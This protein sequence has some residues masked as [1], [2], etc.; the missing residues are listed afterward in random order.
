MKN[1]KDDEK[2]VLGHKDRRILQVAP[3]QESVTA[4]RPMLNMPNMVMIGSFGRNSGKTTLATTLIKHWRNQ[5]PV[6][7]LKVVCVSENGECHR[8]RA[9]CG[10][11]TGFTGGFVLQEEFG[12]APGKDTSR[13]L[14]AGA[15]RVFLLK[16]KREALPQALRAF[17]Q[18]VP[19]GVLIVCESN[20]LRKIVQPGVF[21]MAAG[22]VQ[23][24]AD[25]TSSK[26][27][28]RAV[29]H[30]ADATLLPQSDKALQHIRV[31]VL[32]QGGLR[33]DWYEAGEPLAVKN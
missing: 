20:S 6:F 10:G 2:L 11:C 27:Q 21:L 24:T 16:S 9:G 26:P 18:Q 28:A 13:L 23:A 19:T 5:W 3:P 33:A 31:R 22:D 12:A 14:H 4:V 15:K 25:K 17:L 30:L 1:K 32:P 7:G 29:A 8:G